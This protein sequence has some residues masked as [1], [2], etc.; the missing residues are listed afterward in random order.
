M[1]SRLFMALVTP[2]S[3]AVFGLLLMP[4]MLARSYTFSIRVTTMN[5]RK[6]P[7]ASQ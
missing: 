1:I 3:F 2:M 6:L 4:L 7:M 5:N